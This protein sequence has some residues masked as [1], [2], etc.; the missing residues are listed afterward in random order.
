[1][2]VTKYLEPPT[3]LV[4]IGPQTSLW[5]SSRGCLVVCS[6]FFG[7]EFRRCFPTAHPSYV[8]EI[9][10]GIGAKLVPNFGQSVL[11][12]KRKLILWGIR[13]SM[14]KILKV[15]SS[16]SNRSPSYVSQFDQC[17]FLRK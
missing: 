4:L 17:G 2:K 3:E 12:I 16:V 14:L 9:V 5:I 13:K 11:Y 7:N 1:M 10:H 15:S 6:D 8:C